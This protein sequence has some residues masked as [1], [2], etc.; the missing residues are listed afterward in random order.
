MVFIIL[1]QSGLQ[2]GPGGAN[3]RLRGPTPTQERPRGGPRVTQEPPKSHLGGPKSHPRPPRTAQEPP[4]SRQD[5][6]RGG[7]EGP[8][9]LPGGAPSLE[10]NGRPCKKIGFYEVP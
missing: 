2:R 10:N 4:K 9:R 3:W 6:P 1:A 5:G 8:R 7:Q